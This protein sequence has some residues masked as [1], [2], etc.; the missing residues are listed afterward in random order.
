MWCL[1]AVHSKHCGICMYM[2]WELL[3]AI[4][5]TFERLPWYRALIWA[6]AECGVESCWVIFAD[7]IDDAVP[8]A[9]WLTCFIWHL[10]SCQSQP[11]YIR[12]TRWQSVILPAA[13]VL[14]PAAVAGHSRSLPC[15]EHCSAITASGRPLAIRKTWRHMNHVGS[16]EKGGTPKKKKDDGWENM[17]KRCLIFVTA[18]RI[19]LWN[20]GVSPVVGPPCWSQCHQKVDVASQSSAVLDFHLPSIAKLGMRGDFPTSCIGDLKKKNR[21]WHVHTRTCRPMYPSIWPPCL[22]CLRRCQFSQWPSGK[23]NWPPLDVKRRQ[24]VGAGKAPMPPGLDHWVALHNL[25]KDH[26]L[27]IQVTCFHRAE[28]ELAAVGVWAWKPGQAPVTKQRFCI[29]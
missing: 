23:F 21:S 2:C 3:G 9:V 10:D 26:M 14:R 29:L 8:L 17:K 25:P 24:F 4:V 7:D 27:S 20:F 1:L 12:M 18:T 16:S 11:G 19:A 15:Y 13:G 6:S 22:F 28:E 5:T